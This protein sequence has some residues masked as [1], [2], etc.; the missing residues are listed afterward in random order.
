MKSINQ[1]ELQSLYPQMDENFERRMQHMLNALPHHQ[2]SSRRWLRTAAVML[3]LLLMATAA[4][5][6]SRPAVVEWL[7]GNGDAGNKLEEAA[8]ATTG[9]GEG[10]GIAVRM[11]GVVYDGEQLAFSY[12]VEN[13]APTQAALIALDP[14]MTIAGQAAYTDGG[15]RMVPSPHL[16]VLPVKR[17][18]IAD[19]GWCNDVGEGLDGEVV[20]EL[21]FHV[22]R[23][24]KAFALLKEPDEPLFNA[25]QYEDPFCLELLDS[26]NTLKSFDNVI[27]LDASQLA[28]MNEYTFIERSG[29][30]LEDIANEASHLEETAVIKVIF[31]FDASDPFVYDFSGAESVSLEDCRVEFHCLRFSALATTV[32]VRLIPLENTKQAAMELSQKYGQYGLLDENDEPVVYSDMDYMYEAWPYVTQMDG[33]WVCRYLSQMPGLLEFPSSV[34]FTVTTGEIACFDLPDRG[35]E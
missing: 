7:V 10:D 30:P 23:P 25:E 12:E 11:T 9:T 3:A 8:Q 15:I 6:F 2:K 16:D 33:Q 14:V 24:Q 31:S 19:G 20:C 35:E 32:D 13:N 34:G 17:N 29:Q 26:L 28:V 22:Y 5:G 18:P 21:T 1:Q 27:L 4:Y